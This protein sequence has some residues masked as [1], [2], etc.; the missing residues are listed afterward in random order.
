MNLIIRPFQSTLP[1]RGATKSK[2]DQQQSREISIHA[3]REGSDFF[4]KCGRINMIDFNPRSPRGERRPILPA[5]KPSGRISIHAPRE[6]SDLS[7]LRLARF[8]I[9]ISIHAPREGSDGAFPRRLG[10]QRR[11]SIHAPRE[12]SDRHPSPRHRL[13]R[14][15]IHAPREGSDGGKDGKGISCLYFNPRSP[16]GERRST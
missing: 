4:K 13:R 7:R 5:G 3:P 9:R 11:I 2:Q 14:I 16:R 10:R 15:S 12:G 8:P 1:A 6:G